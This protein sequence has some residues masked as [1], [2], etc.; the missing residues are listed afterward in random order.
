MFV[1]GMLLVGVP[2]I[3][4]AQNFPL[5]DSQTGAPIG[6]AVQKAPA[7]KDRAGN[8]SSQNSRLNQE[9][10]SAPQAVRRQKK[11]VQQDS[12]ATAA[13]RQSGVSE[14]QARSALQQQGYYR[15]GVDGMLG[16]YTREAL[17]N[18]QRHHG[19]YVTSVIDRP[20]LEA[21]GMA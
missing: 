5:I 19:L 4:L 8:A 7:E 18:Y 21:L 12:A 16:P 20:T 9:Q 11:P 17:A 1:A 10:T 2:A 14:V 6:A 3:A 15:G 13:E